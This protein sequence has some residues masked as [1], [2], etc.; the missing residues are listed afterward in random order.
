MYAAI[1]MGMRSRPLS[2]STIRRVHAVLRSALNTAVKHRLIPYSSA[3]HIEPLPRTRSDPIP[4][5]WSSPIGSWTGSPL[6]DSLRC[7]R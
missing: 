7:T 6:T 5:P 3:D 2:P 1:T 4:N